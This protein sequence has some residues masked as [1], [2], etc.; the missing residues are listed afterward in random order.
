MSAKQVLY[1]PY[2]LD[3]KHRKCSSCSDLSHGNARFET[4][5]RIKRLQPKKSKVS[6]LYVPFNLTVI[7]NYLCLSQTSPSFRVV[8][9]SPLFPVVLGTLEALGNTPVTALFYQTCKKI[10]FMYAWFDIHKTHQVVTHDLPYAKTSNWSV[11]LGFFRLIIHRFANFH[12]PDTQI[13]SDLSCFLN[14]NSLVC[15][16]PSLEIRS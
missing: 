1:S 8:I 10:L 13:F 2:K 7:G 3:L 11:S 4:V 5:K 14:I 9:A 15:D 6:V 16:S 12:Y